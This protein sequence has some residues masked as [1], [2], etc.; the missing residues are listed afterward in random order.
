MIIV[1]LF[2][3]LMGIILLILKLNKPPKDENKIIEP[4]ATKELAYV[5]IEEV[6]NAEVQPEKGIDTKSDLVQQSIQEIDNVS[7]LL[8]YTTDIQLLDGR[9]IEIVIPSMSIADNEWTLL[10]QL[11]G[12]DYEIPIDS[13]EYELEKQAFL[14]GVTHVNTFFKKNNID[15]SKIII[16]WGDREFMHKRAQMWLGQ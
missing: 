6:V 4:E 10:V 14:E 12:V 7:A 8:P 1:I 13:T 15:S 11:F 2:I 3:V 5:N 16:I 9:T